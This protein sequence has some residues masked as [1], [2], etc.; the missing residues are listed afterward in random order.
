MRVDTYAQHLE[1]ERL[2][3]LGQVYNTILDVW[4]KFTVP[5]AFLNGGIAIVFAWYATIRHKDE[6]PLYIYWLFPYIATVFTII[7]FDL[8]FDG[9][10][11]IRAS[12]DSLSTLRSKE[13][14]YLV[15]VPVQERVRM[16]KRAKAIRPAFFSVGNFTEFNMN[17][18][19]GVWDEI[20]NQL[21][22]L[23]TL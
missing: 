20:V 15:G 22:F 9:I 4:Y 7:L 2:Y 19:I 23:L 12:E 14:R 1:L 21:M 8:C 16:S 18:P 6:L 5:P 10:L 3:I 11:V 17:V 13:R